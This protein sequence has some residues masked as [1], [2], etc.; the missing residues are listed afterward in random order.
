MQAIPQQFNLVAAAT[1]LG[2]EGG[3]GYGPEMGDLMSANNDNRILKIK[4][5]PSMKFPSRLMYEND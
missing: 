3:G 5:R 2:G 1:W 4:F